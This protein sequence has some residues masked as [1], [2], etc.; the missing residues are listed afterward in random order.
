MNMRRYTPLGTL[1]LHETAYGELCLF[2]EAER[3]MDALREEA[4]RLLEL[5]ERI[6]K[7]VQNPY[8]SKESL[9]LIIGNESRRAVNPS[10]QY[11][12]GDGQEE[13]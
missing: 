8:S 3:E 6:G 13:T 10:Y 9:C 2:A 11:Q 4:K 1:T 12:P 5:L 7:Y